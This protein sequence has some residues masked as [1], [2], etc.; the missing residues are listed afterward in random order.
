MKNKNYTDTINEI[1][2][3]VM[4]KT[5]IEKESFLCIRC[6]TIN[7]LHYKS[8]YLQF[9]FYHKFQNSDF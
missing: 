9:Y 7:S 6:N 1:T 5:K 2:K 4:C 3:C 8:L